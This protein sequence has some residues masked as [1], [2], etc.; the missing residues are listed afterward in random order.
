MMIARGRLCPLAASHMR[1]VTT[2]IPLVALM[3]MATVSTAGRQAMALPIRSGEPGVS[4]MLIRLPLWSA[5]S[6]AE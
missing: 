5:C 6:T 1:R 4:M 2:S 3:T